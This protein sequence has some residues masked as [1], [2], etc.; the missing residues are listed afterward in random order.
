MGEAERIVSILEMISCLD[1]L[2]CG[3][4]VCAHEKAKS[5]AR[6]LGLIQILENLQWPVWKLVFVEGRL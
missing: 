6:K 3:E 2:M 1:R 5:E 4:G